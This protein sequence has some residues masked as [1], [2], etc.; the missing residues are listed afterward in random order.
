M[1]AE[2]TQTTSAQKPKGYRDD[3]IMDDQDN[4]DYGDEENNEP[5]DGEDQQV[6]D[7]P[8]QQLDRV[9]RQGREKV[10]EP[11]LVADVVHMARVTKVLKK[12][13]RDPK[14]IP[15][16]VREWKNHMKAAK[17]IEKALSKMGCQVRAMADS[18]SSGDEGNRS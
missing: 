3:Q 12:R 1:T 11:D 8:E 16:L 2:T 4:H 9:D 5:D 15:K 6:A 7:Q 10:E 18:S 14:N 17:R 13:M